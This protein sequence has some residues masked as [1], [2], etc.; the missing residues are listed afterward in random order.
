MEKLKE[1]LE[2]KKLKAAGKR[3]RYGMKKLSVDLVSCVLGYFVFFSPTIVNA[4]AE[5]T[6]VEPTQIVELVKEESTYKKE[7]VKEE[8][9]TLQ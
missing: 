4:Q 1:V 7:E 6:Q 8:E 2:A 5:E 3:P 9:E